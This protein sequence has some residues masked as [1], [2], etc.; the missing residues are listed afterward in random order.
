MSMS[1][2]SSDDA[3]GQD[4][5]AAQLAEVLNGWYRQIAYSSN[6]MERSVCDHGVFLSHEEHYSGLWHT[7]AQMAHYA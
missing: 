7:A 6:M 4:D 1:E 5:E 3:A 2:Q